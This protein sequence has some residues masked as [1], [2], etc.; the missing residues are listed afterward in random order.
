MDGSPP[1]VM[2]FDGVCNLCN[3][4]VNFV[5]DHD[6]AGRFR[7]ASLQSPAGQALLAQHGLSADE[8]STMVLV[9]DGK[10]YLR[11]GAALR[12]ARHLDGLWPLTA[13]LL[14]V[15]APLRDAVYNAVATNRYRLMGQA[16]QCRV[17]TPEL[18]HRFL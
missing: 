6:R 10:T 1:P 5:L 16:Q 8:P 13:A 9:E 18:Q 11:S 12:V 15:P 4:A 7:F 2:L 14:A 3:A 17:P